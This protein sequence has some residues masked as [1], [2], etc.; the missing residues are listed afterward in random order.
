MTPQVHAALF[1]CVDAINVTGV[2]EYTAFGQK[3]NLA[4]GVAGSSPGPEAGEGDAIVGAIAEDIYRRIYARLQASRYPG[5]RGERVPFAARLSAANSSMRGWEPGWSVLTRTGSACVLH[6]D[7]LRIHASTSEMFPNPDIEGVHRPYQIDVG[8]EL[9]NVI[10]GWYVALGETPDPF[11]E[12]DITT[13]VYFNIDA[14]AGVELVAR[15]CEQLNRCGIP[16]RLKVP[17]DPGSYGRTDAAVLYLRKRIYRA[18]HDV[19][20]G[21]F[22]TVRTREGIPAFARKIARGI[23]VAED[24]A[25]GSSFGQSRSRL[26]ARGLW[27]AFVAQAES[28]EARLR[29]VIG[30][31]Q[32]AGLDCARPHLGPRS[33]DIYESARHGR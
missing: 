33:E 30:E 10:P 32:G 24:P 20:L 23:A 19:L 31:F 13:R 29:H 15:C 18:G 1:D 11:D 21:L 17:D 16:F 6:R 27:R 25:D 4:P 28:R 5:S 14:A 7:G 26:V 22:D 8:K 2:N 9:F 3:R 12:P